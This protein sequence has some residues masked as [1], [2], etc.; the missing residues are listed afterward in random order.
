MTTNPSVGIVVLNWNNYE[1]TKECLSSIFKIDYEPYNIYVVDNGST[2]NSYTKLKETFPSCNYTRNDEN[3]GFSSGINSGINQAME[4]NCD[5]LLILNN[6]TIVE[7]DFLQPLVETAETNTQVAAVG[8]IIYYPDKEQIWFAGGHINRY[9]SKIDIN[10]NIKET[11]EYATEYIIGTMMLLNTEYLQ[12]YGLLNDD[13][14]FGSEDQEFCQKAIKNG[15]N[16]MVNPDSK[17]IH[18]INSKSGS[19]N[20][21]RFYHN[22]YNR[23]YFASHHL[24]LHE[25]M[26]FYPY[27]LANRSVLLVIWLFKRRFTMILSVL[28]AVYDF[29]TG[30]QK[31]GTEFL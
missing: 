5:Y 20:E 8:G 14:F 2:D 26:I 25:K 6:D 10:T 29:I 30:V 7:P 27:F 4:D 15:W 9:F 21:F 18:K 19:G 16:L 23:L 13:Y 17:I 1:D 12:K 11:T 28:Y 31:K 22:T 24:N 3:I